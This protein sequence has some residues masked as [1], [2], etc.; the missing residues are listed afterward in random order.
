MINS[1]RNGSQLLPENGF[2]KSIKTVSKQLKR[3]KAHIVKDAETEQFYDLFSQQ[4]CILQA[5]NSPDA[6]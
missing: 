5:L 3:I 4:M 6:Y 2:S 1:I